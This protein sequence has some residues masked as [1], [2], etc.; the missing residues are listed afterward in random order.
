VCVCVCVCGLKINETETELAYLTFSIKK[1]KSEKKPA[2]S[3]VLSLGKVLNRD[4]IYL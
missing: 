1:G 4:R 3:L 2:S